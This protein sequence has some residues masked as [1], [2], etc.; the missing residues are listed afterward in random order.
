MKTRSCFQLVKRK[1]LSFA[2][3]ISFTVS[4]M[5]ETRMQLLQDSGVRQT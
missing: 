3:K 2:K 4:L 5:C 1:S